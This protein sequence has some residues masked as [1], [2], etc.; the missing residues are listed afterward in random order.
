[1]RAARALLR[2][3]AQDLADKANVG[4]AMIQQA[5]KGDGPI[6]MIPSTADAVRRVLEAARI[7]FILENGEGAGVRL[8]KPDQ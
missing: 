8:R 2:G 3:R 6:T 7:N 4:I 1:M 5:E